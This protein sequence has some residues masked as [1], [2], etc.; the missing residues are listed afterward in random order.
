MAQHPGCHIRS[1]Y[2]SRT[3]PRGTPRWPVWLTC[4]ALPLSSIC[5]RYSLGTFSGTRVFREY[6]KDASNGRRILNIDLNW[7]NELR[8]RSVRGFLFTDYVPFESESGELWK[9]VSFKVYGYF[10]SCCCVCGW[11]FVS[12]IT[13]IVWMLS[14]FIQEL[15]MF[16]LRNELLKIYNFIFRHTSRKSYVQ[17]RDVFESFPSTAS[18]EFFFTSM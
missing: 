12:A 14:W 15:K 18:L 1:S 10:V 9:I 7:L 8:K 4:R 5:I 11:Y 3:I 16:R 17:F 2:R 13:S 6:R